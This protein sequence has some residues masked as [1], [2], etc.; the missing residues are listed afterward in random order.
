MR[1][2]LAHYALAL[3]LATTPV[4]ASDAYPLLSLGVT[5][6]NPTLPITGPGPLFNF[7][8]GDIAIT[9]ALAH[10]GFALATPL[11][12]EK[13]GGSKGKWI[14]GLSWIAVSVL[15]EWLLH[16]PESPGD[17]YPSEVRTDLF[18]RI[19]PT[20]LVLTW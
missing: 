7:G 8:D 16:A 3:A 11:L 9:N 12:G 4:L 6:F 1:I 15:Q 5:G 14:A 10:V 13:I 20:L 2:P 17:H 18:T 19:V